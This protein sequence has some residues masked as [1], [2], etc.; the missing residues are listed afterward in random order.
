MADQVVLLKS[1]DALS[2]RDATRDIYTTSDWSAALHRHATDERHLASAAAIDRFN[3]PAGATRSGSEYRPAPSE[4]LGGR[5]STA[6]KSPLQQPSA[7]E[8]LGADCAD[9]VVASVI[10]N[11]CNG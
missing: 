1:T 6:K 10:R 3:V 9:C 7:S 8:Y 11:R 4:Y 5:A 2:N